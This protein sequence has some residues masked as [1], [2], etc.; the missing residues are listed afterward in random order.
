MQ[1]IQRVGLPNLL[2][3]SELVA[4]S[5]GTLGAEVAVRD[6]IAMA[7]ARQAQQKAGELRPVTQV[8]AAGK[9]QRDPREEQRDE[10][11][12][13]PEDD[14]GLLEDEPHHTIDLSA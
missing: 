13:T 9:R 14:G 2:S 1:E 7:L 6:Q 11:D 10:H 5:R 3:Q 12:H 8:E 4:R